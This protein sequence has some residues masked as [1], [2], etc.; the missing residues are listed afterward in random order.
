MANNTIKTMKLY[1]QVE[2]VFNELR[3]L[4]LS[5]ADKIEVETLSRF[6]Q[7][8]YE[9]VEAVEE[10][11]LRC[12]IGPQSRVLEV[13]SGIGGPARYLAHRTS[14]Q[15]TALELQA[16]LNEIGR[17]LTARTNLSALVNHQQGDFLEAVSGEKYDTL[18]SWLAF[19]HIPDRSR[20]LQQCFDHT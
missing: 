7:Y 17:N 12:N 1:V 20:L 10:A 4:G 18:V 14:C 6:D 11:I 9:G 3:V 13:G 8:H 2:R 19:L 5:D 15:V 16:D